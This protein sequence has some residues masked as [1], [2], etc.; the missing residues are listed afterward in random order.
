MSSHE[1]DARPA[2]PSL[3]SLPALPALISHNLPPH[4]TAP[5]SPLNGR[6]LSTSSGVTITVASPA[7]AYVRPEASHFSPLRSSPTH[8]QEFGSIASESKFLRDFFLLS[9]TQTGSAPSGRWSSRA[10]FVASGYQAVRGGGRQHQWN[11]SFLFALNERKSRQSGCSSG[12]S[13]FAF[14]LLSL[15]YGL[16][17]AFP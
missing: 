7:P 2:L 15:I 6:R 8:A 5:T 10:C 16:A 12:F 11:G 3:A 17:V 4:V 13:K 1:A 9:L 14:S